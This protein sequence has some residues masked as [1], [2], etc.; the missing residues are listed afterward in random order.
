MPHLQYQGRYWKIAGDEFALPAMCSATLRLFWVVTLLVILCLSFDR[1]AECSEGWA[2]ILFIIAS[3]VVFALSIACEMFIFRISLR[4]T[5]LEVSERAGLDFYMNGHVVLGVAQ[6]LLA[7]IGF[8][9]TQIS[10]F[11]CSGDFYSHTD[12]I[13]LSVVVISQLIDVLGLLCCC[14]MFSHKEFGTELDQTGDDN[15]AMDIWKSRC[16]FLCKS[17]QMCTCNLFG[18]SNITEDLEAVARVLTQFFHHDGI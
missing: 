8:C 18:G 7:V 3:I 2:I 16:K 13:L 1:L 12:F 9:I 14:Y 6:A 4:G 11:P 17:A 15:A 5:M 10:S